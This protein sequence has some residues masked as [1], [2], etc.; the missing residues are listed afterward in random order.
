MNLMIT[1]HLKQGYDS[2]KKLFDGD[3]A[4]AE[5]CDDSKTMVGRVSDDTAL[6]V[7]FNVDQAKM[8]ARLSSPEFAELVKDY[9]ESHDVF[10]LESVAGD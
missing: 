4:R 5:F 7:L 2:W 8:N 9:I 10:A 3:A 1:A 6:I